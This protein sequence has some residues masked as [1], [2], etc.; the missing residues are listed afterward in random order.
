[1]KRLA[2]LFAAAGVVVPGAQASPGKVQHETASAGTVVA[3]VSYRQWSPRN[4]I[5]YYVRLSVVRDGVEVYDAVVP[6]LRI[7]GDRAGNQPLGTLSGGRTIT[8]RDLDGDGEPEIV[9]D[10]YWGGAHCCYWTRIYRWDGRAYV[11]RAHLWGDTGYRLQDLRPP[12]PSFVTVDDRFA[13]AFTSFAGSA[14]PVQISDYRGGR[15]VNV[16][17]SFP[18]RVRRDA[19]RQLRWLAAAKRNGE[20]RGVLAAWAADECL[21]GRSAY[22][23]AWLGAHPALY[24]GRFADA[25]FGTGPTAQDYRAALRRFLRRT[26]Y[27]S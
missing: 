2:L 13:Y 18:D 14:M 16:T 20:T 3:T 27:L 6:H 11:Q 9:L 25:G 1:M 19:E 4:P 8:V 5:R 21:L 23:F 15:L 7:P 17:R 24:T 22:A 12:S 10:F 26:G